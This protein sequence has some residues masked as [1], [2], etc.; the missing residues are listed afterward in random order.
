M[1]YHNRSITVQNTY[2]IISTH[3]LNIYNLNTIIRFPK[4]DKLVQ[5]RTTEMTPNEKSTT[6]VQWANMKIIN[7]QSNIANVNHIYIS[8]NPVKTS[9]KG[10]RLKQ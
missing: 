7:N 8:L 3:Y 4:S 6:S 9:T 5:K 1:K 2:C 10:K